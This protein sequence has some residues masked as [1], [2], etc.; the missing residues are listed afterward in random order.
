MRE[1]VESYNIESVVAAARQ[2]G[3]QYFSGFLNDTT[4]QPAEQYVSQIFDGGSAME[5][6]G[7]ESTVA[8]ARQ[9]SEL[10][11]GQIVDNMA[12]VSSADAVDQTLELFLND[13]VKSA[14]VADSSEATDGLYQPLIDILA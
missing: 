12:E 6:S 1:A 2:T 11:L 10:A 8:A 13:I 4:S 9:S 3:G 5:S 7:I 14:I